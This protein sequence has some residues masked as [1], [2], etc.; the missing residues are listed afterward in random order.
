MP[1]ECPDIHDE[2]KQF[3]EWL[4][5]KCKGW[6]D[7]NDSMVTRVMKNL[8]PEVVWKFLQIYVKDKS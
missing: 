8:L 7:S 4:V 3:A 2:T 5:K 6:I 1:P